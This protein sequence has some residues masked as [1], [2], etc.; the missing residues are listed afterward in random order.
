LLIQ[1]VFSFGKMRV[2]RGQSQLISYVEYACAHV[3]RL[4]WDAGGALEAANIMTYE[5]DKF[6]ARDISRRMLQAM[7]GDYVTGFMALQHVLVAHIITRIRPEERATIL[8]GAITYMRELFA[9]QAADA[10]KETSA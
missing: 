1:P 9:V 8:E 2:P 3:A 6:T 7:D 10:A 5:L 4:L